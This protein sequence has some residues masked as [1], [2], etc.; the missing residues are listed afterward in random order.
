MADNFLVGKWSVLVAAEEIP[1][2]SEPAVIQFYKDGSCSVPVQLLGS[3]SED[4][5]EFLFYQAFENK[6]IRFES[7]EPGMFIYRYAIDGARLTLKTLDG[8]SFAFERKDGKKSIF[9]AVPD[10]VPA[11]ASKEPDVD[12]EPEAHE[13]KCPSCGKINQNYVGTCGCGEAKPKD[14]PAFNWAEV[15]PELAR[16]PEEEEPAPIAVEEPKP[17]KQAP[18]APEREVEVPLL[19]QDQPELCRHLRLRRGKAEGRSRLQ[20]GGGTSRARPQA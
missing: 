8:R 5:P 6:T 19:R 11:K 10:G 7:G 20:L 13:W 1:E 16:K 17:K 15:H 4:F 3:E 12:R 14:T 18:P 9:K 2:G